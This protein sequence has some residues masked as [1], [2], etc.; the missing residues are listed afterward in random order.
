MEKWKKKIIQEIMQENCPE[1][2]GKNFLLEE[3]AKCLV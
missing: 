1:L 3:P 2:K